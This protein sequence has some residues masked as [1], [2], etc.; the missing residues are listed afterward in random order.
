MHRFFAP[1]LRPRRRDRH[2]AEGRSRTPDARA[3]HRRRRDGRGLRR[4]RTRVPGARAAARRAGTFKVQLLSRVDPVAESPVALTLVQAVLKGDKMDDVVRD[5]VMLGVPADSADRQ[6]THRNDGRRAAARRAAR[7][8][9]P[10]R[11]RLGEAVAARGAAGHPYAAHARELPRRTATGAAADARRTR[12]RC[13]RSSRSACC[14]ASRYRRTPRCSSVRKAGGTT[15]NALPLAERGVR[16]D[17]ARSPHAQGRRRSRRRA[18]HSRFLMAR[19]L[20]PLSARE[21]LSP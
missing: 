5:A 10:R 18:Q 17:V 8:L 11:A 19:P 4:T 9:A 16:L 2:A 13:R 3:A 15:P 6:P 20:K 14:A 1:A 21:S 7:S 12:G